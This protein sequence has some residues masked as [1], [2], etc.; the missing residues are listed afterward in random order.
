MSHNITVTVS[1]QQSVSLSE[2]QTLDIAK[3]QIRLAAD[4]PEESYLS[5]DGKVM[6]TNSSWSSPSRVLRVATE[7]DK[8]AFGAI[9]MMNSHRNNLERAKHLDYIAN[10]ESA[11]KEAKANHLAA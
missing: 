10:L 3:R 1:Q 11:L 9:N 5:E 4:L 2:E 8:I 7:Q 6:Y